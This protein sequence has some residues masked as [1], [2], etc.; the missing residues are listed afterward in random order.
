MRDF[1]SFYKRFFENC[2]A[3]D[4]VVRKNQPFLFDDECTEAFNLLKEKLINPPILISPDWDKDFEL[5]CDASDYAL[6]A[7]LGAVLGAMRCN[8]SELMCDVTHLLCKQGTKWRLIELHHYRERAS[9][10]TKDKK[11]AEN[12]VADHLSRLDNPELQPYDESKIQDTIPDEHLM[13]VDLVDEV[14]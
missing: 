11:G 9:C 8:T 14:S 2:P 7:V 5:M 10:E 4:Q 1:T 13:R 12:V 3:Y 6:S